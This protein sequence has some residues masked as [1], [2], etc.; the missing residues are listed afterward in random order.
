MKL[1]LPLFLLFALINTAYAQENFTG[2]VLENKVNIPLS[3]VKVENLNSHALSGT[4]EK[5]KFTIKAKINDLICFTSLGYEPDTVLLVNLKYK[6]IYLTLKQNMLN[7]VKVKNTDGN[8][9][10]KIPPAGITPL[11]GT[12]VRYQTDAAGNNI[13]GI[14]LNIFDSHKDERKRELTRKLEDEG[15]QQQEIEK[16]F[17]PKNLSNYVPITGTEMSNF[18]IL[19]KPD[20]QT[21]YNANF[22]FLN[23]VNASYK[24][25]LEIPEEKRKSKAFLSLTGEN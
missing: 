20:I 13:G 19:Y 25:F 5:G 17:N 3:N 1:L 22:N 18:I 4:D 14:K 21:F 8:F 9:N 7:E 24:K 2:R 15:Q 23:Y 11:G 6:E 10:F 12:V 16:L